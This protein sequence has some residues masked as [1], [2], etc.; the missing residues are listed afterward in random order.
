MN[1][2]N[3]NYDNFLGFGYHKFSGELDFQGHTV[4]MSTNQTS[5]QYRQ[6]G[7]VLKGGVIKNLVIDITLDALVPKNDTLLGLVYQNYGRIENVMI[8]LHETRDQAYTNTSFSPLVY[9]NYPGAEIV[10]FAIVTHDD[11]YMHRLNS[12]LVYYNQGLIKNGYF[13]GRELH[14]D[15]DST[16]DPNLGVFAYSV[17]PLGS[18]ENVYAVGNLNF[19]YN[20]TE[21]KY[22]YNFINTW[23]KGFV[24][25]YFFFLQRSIFG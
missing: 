15:L 18:F 16:Y 5:A 4:Y 23:V 14:Y 25:N 12:F 2:I 17:S 6:I 7:A 24:F 13:Q 19:K 10:N 3:N 21:I 22:K 9:Y 20:E 8:N 1:L 11:I